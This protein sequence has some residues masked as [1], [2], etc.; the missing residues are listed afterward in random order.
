FAIMG[1]VAFIAV[2]KNFTRGKRA[3]FIEVWTFFRKAFFSLLLLFIVVGGI[4]AGVFT[5]TEASVIAVLY[6]A[7]LA[8][9]YGDIK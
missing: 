4:V 9:I 3:T 2:S 1:Y 8:L 6:A 7:I 5:A